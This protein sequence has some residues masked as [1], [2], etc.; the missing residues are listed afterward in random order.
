MEPHDTRNFSRNCSSSV[1]VW[2]V[3]WGYGDGQ[4]DLQG[5]KA[6]SHTPSH[7]RIRREMFS[8]PSVLYVSHWW[9]NW[10]K[11][12]W[13]HSTDEEHFH[14]QKNFK[15]RANL[16]WLRPRDQ[17]WR[18]FLEMMLCS[19]CFLGMPKKKKKILETLKALVILGQ[20]VLQRSLLSHSRT[21]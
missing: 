16:G 5:R 20:H 12:N 6:V 11:L 19:V 17:F 9:L 10:L 13:K 3:R 14:H 21:R 18:L 4:K 8:S 2:E 15:F 1:R 7:N